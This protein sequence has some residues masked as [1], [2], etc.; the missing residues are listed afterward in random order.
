MRTECSRKTL[1]WI[2]LTNEDANDTTILEA[3]PSGTPLE[4]S[5]TISFITW[6]IDGLDGCN[7][8]E[9]ARGVCS[10]LAL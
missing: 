7:L 2:D 1:A 8:P 9:R 4:D 6:N 5:S 3:S 10:C